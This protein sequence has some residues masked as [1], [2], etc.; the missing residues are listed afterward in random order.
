MLITGGSGGI[1]EHVV[2]LLSEKGVK[3]AIM[4]I[5]A[6]VYKLGKCFTTALQFSWRT[7]V[8]CRTRV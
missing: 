7:C 3:V 1:G 5:V 4:D 2:K 6:P 8:V